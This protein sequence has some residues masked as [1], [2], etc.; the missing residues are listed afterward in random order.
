MV[1]AR[2]VKKWLQPLAARHADL[3][4]VGRLLIVTPVRHHLRGVLIGRTSSA[5]CITP[6][7]LIHHSFSPRLG[8]HLSWG[9]LLSGRTGHYWNTDDPNMPADLLVAIETQA[10]PKLRAVQTLEDFVAAVPSTRGGHLWSI[11]PEGKSLI[12]IAMGELEQAR[13]SC[14]EKI[15]NRP[16]PGPKEADVTK[17]E[18]AGAKLLCGL[19]EKN[20]IEG[21][22]RTLHSWEEASVKKLKLAPYWEPSPFPVELKMQAR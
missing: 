10:L 4:I 21:L 17:A 1:V 6:Q 8:Y 19:L 18:V 9:D 7:W 20:D 15:C 5:N 16:D 14:R 2:D 12:D 3:A 13:A 22:I 11:D